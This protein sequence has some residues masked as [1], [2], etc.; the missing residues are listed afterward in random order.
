MKKEIV[1][2]LSL[3]ALIFSLCACG[4]ANNP[5]ATGTP[6]AMPTPDMNDG[7]VNDEDGII[8][9]DDTGVVPT[10]TPMTDSSAKPSASAKA[11]DDAAKK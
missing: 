7:I 10:Q 1:Y 2:I 11:T 9:D 8:T 6:P 4:A 3:A 5:S